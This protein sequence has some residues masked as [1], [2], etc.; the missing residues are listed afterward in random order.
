MK[1]RKARFAP[2]AS[3]DAMKYVCL[4]SAEKMMEHMTPAD[5]ARHYDEYRE[6][7]EQIYASGHL[8]GCNRLLPPEAATTVRVRSG[9]VLLTDGPYVETKEQL[10]GFY[11][12]NAKDMN[13]A[14]QIAARIPGARFGCVEVRP[15]A[16]DPQTREALAAAT[17]MG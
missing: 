16:D 2:Q 8:V 3:E 9:Q 4:I 10:G 7:T 15:I 1:A 5:A 14:I 13:E 6:F 11:V 12:I 17:S